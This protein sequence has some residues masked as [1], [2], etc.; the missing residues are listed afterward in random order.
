MAEHPWVLRAHGH[1][2]LLFRARQ[3]Q[4]HCHQTWGRTGFHH[5]LHYLGAV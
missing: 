3:T 1:Q 5:L 2:A 4:E